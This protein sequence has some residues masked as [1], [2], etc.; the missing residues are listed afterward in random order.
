MDLS[1]PGWQ[2]GIRMGSAKDG[3]VRYFIPDPDPKNGSSGAEGVA[4]INRG[5]VVYGAEVGPKDFVRYDRK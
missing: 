2:R 4:A 5:A 3:T 1:H